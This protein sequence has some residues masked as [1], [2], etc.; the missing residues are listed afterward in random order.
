MIIAEPRALIGFA[1]ARVASGTVGEQ[2]PEGFQSA[3]FV[4]AHGLIDMVV[5]R[6]ELRATIGRVL[7]LL[8]PAAVDDGWQSDDDRRRG[9][10]GVLSGFAEKLG[11]AVSET[12]G[13][14]VEPEA[15]AGNG[16]VPA[17]DRT[18]E[19]ES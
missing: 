12:V 2:L 7:R 14:D 5:A 19:R 3:E 18:T 15:V 13:L 6:S 4:L 16:R 1:G 8:P 17:H 9:P 11:G 10:I